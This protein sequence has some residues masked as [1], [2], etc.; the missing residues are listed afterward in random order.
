M[1]F[2]SKICAYI[3]KFYSS[4][5]ISKNFGYGEN[6]YK[7]ST[8]ISISSFLGG[9]LSIFASMVKK[10]FV[11]VSA[12]GFPQ[13]ANKN[14]HRWRLPNKGHPKRAMNPETQDVIFIES[15]RILFLAP[16]CRI[17]EIWN[18]F[19]CKEV[20]KVERSSNH[21]KNWKKISSDS[22][23]DFARSFSN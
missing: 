17:F 20:I 13:D 8:T 12:G 10:T 7:N 4:F 1:E 2:H 18:F 6:F 16:V 9:K 15:W 21:A 3:T 23:V 19:S 5:K 14:F 22:E 11:E